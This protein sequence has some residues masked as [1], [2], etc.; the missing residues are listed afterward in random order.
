MLFA[1][2]GVATEEMLRLPWSEV[3]DQ[4]LRGLPIVYQSGYLLANAQRL[5]GKSGPAWAK[6]F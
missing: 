2:E 5:E 6:E 3:I 1:D 4:S